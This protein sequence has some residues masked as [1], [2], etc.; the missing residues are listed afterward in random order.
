[1]TYIPMLAFIKSTSK[2]KNPIDTISKF[3]P[4]FYLALIL[5]FFS[6]QDLLAQKRDTTNIEQAIENY[7][8][9]WRTGNI[10]LLKKTF[11]LEAGVVLW[12]DKNGESEQLKSMALSELAN[13][14]KPDDGFGIGYTIQDLK[15]IDSK[16]AI[17]TIKVPLPRKKSYYI[18]CLEMQKINGEWKIVLKSFVYFPKE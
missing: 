11:D 12:V 15:I 1:M 14:V 6:P 3:S 13:G 4:M 16:L 2:Q 7:I 5:G 10:E 17:A 8:A 9:G 18:D